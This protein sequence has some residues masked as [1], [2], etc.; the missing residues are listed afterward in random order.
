MQKPE[1]IGSNLYN[2][3]KMD[4][5]SYSSSCNLLDI[6]SGRSFAGWCF[7]DCPCS[8]LHMATETHA[9]NSDSLASLLYLL[10][11]DSVQND[12]QAQ[13]NCEVVVL[14]NASIDCRIVHPL[15][16]TTL[17]MSIALVMQFVQ[18]FSSSDFAFSFENHLSEILVD[19]L[20]EWPSDN[21][22][23]FRVYEAS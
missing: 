21:F 22:F 8:C 6:D 20:D 23:H 3:E 19:T 2:S 5:K 1:L 9:K 14:I 10:G 4:R 18:Y 17:E 11:D 12:Q 7:V 15:F 13:L 16:R